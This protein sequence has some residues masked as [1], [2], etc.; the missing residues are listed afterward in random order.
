MKRNLIAIALLGLVFGA[1]PVVACETDI[2]SEP[3]WKRP[4]TVPEP[5]PQG[6]ASQSPA[7]APDLVDDDNC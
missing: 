7:S 6:T 1:K 2:I 3:H 5:A 4:E